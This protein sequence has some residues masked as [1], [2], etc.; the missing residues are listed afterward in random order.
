MHFYSHLRE[1]ADSW[2]LLFMTGVFVGVALY[3]FRPSAKAVQKAAALSIF[4][5][6]DHPK[7]S[8]QTTRKRS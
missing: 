3:A 7:S 6:E 1:F 5:H 8:A 2:F 4:N